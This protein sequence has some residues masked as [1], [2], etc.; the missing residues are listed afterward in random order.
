MANHFVSELGEVG[1]SKLAWM[2]NTMLV[3]GGTCITLHILGLALQIR[4]WFR[5]ILGVSGLI[6]GVSAAMVGVFPM[7]NIQPH[8]KVAMLF[9]NM[10]LFTMT[11]FAIYVAFS[12]KQ[13]YP[14]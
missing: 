10:G 13:E 14:R 2:F 5:I 7:N 4:S 1:V 8:I 6:T 9:F 12:R 3:L 11:I